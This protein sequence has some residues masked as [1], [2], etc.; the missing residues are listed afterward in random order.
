MNYIYYDNQPDLEAHEET[1]KQNISKVISDNDI[2]KWTWYG[3]RM[4]EEYGIQ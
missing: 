4:V 3:S 2:D 1:F